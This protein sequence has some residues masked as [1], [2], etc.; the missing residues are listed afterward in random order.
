MLT[1]D[2]Q[3]RKELRAALNSPLV[4]KEYEKRLREL[5]RRQL[6]WRFGSLPAAIARRVAR[7]GVA[8]LERWADRTFTAASLD[9]VFACGDAHHPCELIAAGQ[10]VPPPM[11]LTSEQLLRKE[12]FDK[13]FS[14]GYEMGVWLGIDQGQY[15]LFLKLLKNRFSRIPAAV[16]ESVELGSRED[17]EHWALRIHKAFEL[18]DVFAGPP[19]TFWEV[20][21]LGEREDVHQRRFLLALLTERF[22]SVPAT[23]ASDVEQSRG[24]RLEY[25]IH[26]AQRAATLDD[27]F[28]TR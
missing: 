22:G 9:D 26:R 17:I 6:N 3:L 8:E 11:E 15:E 7:A 19:L 21:V 23:A 13:G 4:E 25:L 18:D 16:L 20:V 24:A 28:A 12:E 1:D 2:E 14:Q 5:L 27:V 10:D